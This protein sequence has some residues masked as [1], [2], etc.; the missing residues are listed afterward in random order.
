MSWNCF[1]VLSPIYNLYFLPLP[2][3]PQGIGRHVRSMRTVLPGKAGLWSLVLYADSR[4]GRVNS[5]S[6]QS[7]PTLQWHQRWGQL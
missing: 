4:A 1:F 5:V 3:P 6:L 2:F 7:C